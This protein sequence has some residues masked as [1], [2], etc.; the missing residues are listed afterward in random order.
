[1]MNRRRRG[2]RKAVVI[3]I[4]EVLAA[5]IALFSLVL[6]SRG[7]QEASNLMQWIAGLL[8][9][10]GVLLP[11]LVNPLEYIGFP[12]LEQMSLAHDDLARQVKNQWQEEERVLRLSQPV[13]MPVRW[14][15]TALRVM[16]HQELVA[17]PGLLI[18]GRSDRID[19]LAGMF[20]TLYRRR[21]VILGPP[22][23]GKTTLAVQLLLKLLRSQK[24]GEPVPVII[25]LAGW[26]TS[27]YPRMHDWVAARLADAYPVLQTDRYG[28]GMPLALASHSKILP[29]LDGFDELSDDVRMDVLTAINSSLSEDDQLI[30]TSRTQEYAAAVQG[31][32]EVIPAAA[33][34]EAERLTS[35]EIA[36]YLKRCRPLAGQHW[37]RLID[38]LRG[39][40]AGRL[41]AALSTPLGLWLLRS[42]Y[43]SSADPTPLLDTVRFPNEASVRGALFEQLIPSLISARRPGRNPADGFPRRQWDSVNVER[44]LGYLA[45]HM[46]QAGM[47]NLAW[48]RL[49]RLSPLTTRTITLTVAL[50]SVL[51]LGLTIAFGS[52]SFIRLEI[53]PWGGILGGLIVGLGGGI[54]L[55]LAFGS[56]SARWL[57][58]DP[59]KAERL[60]RGVLRRRIIGGITV[61]F[62]FGVVG[63]VTIGLAYGIVHGITAGIEVG[64]SF[65]I[66]SGLTFGL[67]VALVSGA[68]AG[69]TFGL[70]G[71]FTFGLVGVLVFGLIERAENRA[72]W[73]SASTPHSTLRADRTLTLVGTCVIGLAF[74]LAFGIISGFSFALAYALA[75]GLAGRESHAW[76]VYMLSVIRL[77]ISRKLPLHVMALLDDAHRL[78]LIRTFGPEY[79]FRHVDLQEYLASSYKTGF[80]ANRRK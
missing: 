52:G 79:Q 33:V 51:A 5:V 70:S 30:L 69:L 13:P 8:A 78:G 50:A 28:R 27:N 72:M 22:G 66:I 60:I 64:I 44:W 80:I 76:V 39:E 15:Q 2:C 49:V 73:N 7:L 21:L 56:G 32:G 54:G 18:A 41:A 4:L 59:G 10:T 16:D 43:P 62:A 42:V 63:G 57:E 61:G 48:W 9:L 12:S 20:R 23:S 34:I 74:T 67:T 40:S 17:P 25:S 14:K 19:M 31:S 26:D 75:G 3:S 55:W 35:T 46:R 47:P 11:L 68:T 71:G 37:Q 45:Y 6:Q 1:M 53:G 65:G 77:A 38:A 36:E 58:K 29:I 24:E